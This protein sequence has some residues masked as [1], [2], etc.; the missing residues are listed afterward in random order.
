VRLAFQGAVVRRA[1]LFACVVGPLLIAINHADAIAAGAV[2]G[3]RALKMALTL[4]VPY[5]VSSV[6]SVLALRRAARTGP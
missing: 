1:V 6:S 2:D 3:Q 5:V 4:L